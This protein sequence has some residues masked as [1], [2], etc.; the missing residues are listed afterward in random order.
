M[1]T[2]NINEIKKFG[3]STSSHCAVTFGYKGKYIEE[4]FKSKFL[5]LRLDNQLNWKENIDQ[6]IPKVSGAYYA[7]MLLMLTHQQH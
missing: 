6:M 1:L 5:G 3:T 4:T 7:V 2:K